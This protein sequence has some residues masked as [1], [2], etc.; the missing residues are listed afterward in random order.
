MLAPENSSAAARAPHV[1]FRDVHKAFGSH[2]VLRGLNWTLPQGAVIGLLGTNG[3][4]KSTLLKCLLGLLRPG[5]GAITIDGHDVWDLPSELKARIG[6][7]DQQPRFYPWMRG[8]QLLKY[9]AAFYPAWNDALCEDLASRWDVPLDRKFG[10]LSPGQQHKLAI[11][12]GMGHEPDL[13]VLD[14]PVS[15]LDPL[16]RREFLKTLLEYA[17]EKDRTVLFSTHITSDLERVATHVG[18]LAA[19]AI[20]WFEE[21]D[22][23][24]DRT[25]R[26]RIRSRDPLPTDFTVTGAMHR[27]LLTPHTMTL[28]AGSTPQQLDE[29]RSRAG[30]D[31]E[32]D[33]L[34]LE[35]IFLE[36]HA[37][38]VA[39]VET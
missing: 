18:I 2:Q 37:A 24:K 39:H 35:E 30:V 7:V 8:S 1:E 16:A 19:G 31:V 38:E 6:Y 21:L 17:G 20:R 4:G 9:V 25:K 29:L 5:R 22:E 23:L 13:L 26:L 32:I 11:L 10:T 34:N 28:I 12:L 3:S 14:E 36:L 15:S 33:D 27:R